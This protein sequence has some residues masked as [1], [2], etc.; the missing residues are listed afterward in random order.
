MRF[1]IKFFFFFFLLGALFFF[2]P[3]LEETWIFVQIKFLEV[4]P[5]SFKNRGSGPLR[6]AEKMLRSEIL[7]DEKKGLELCVALANPT[8]L[9]EILP[10]LRVEN[11][12]LTEL[13]L[14]AIAAMASLEMKDPL[15]KIVKTADAK[16]R[17]AI[18]LVL[19]ETLGDTVDRSQLFY[20][21]KQDPS[22]VIRMALCDALALHPGKDT[23]TILKELLSDEELE[24]AQSAST[25]L[26]NVG[27]ENEYSDIFTHFGSPKNWIDQWRSLRLITLFPEK[28]VT[29]LVARYVTSSYPFLAV[30]AL[31]W[32]MEKGD[33]R[34]FS[35]IIQETDKTP[36]GVLKAHAL[37][38]IAVLAPMA[39]KE[40][41][42]LLT[43]L[44]FLKMDNEDLSAAALE[45][46]RVLKGTLAEQE[47]LTFLDNPN[48]ELAAQA[49]LTLGSFANERY[50]DTLLGFLQ[51]EHAPL[52]IAAYRALLE[53]SNIPKIPI[54]IHPCTS[55]E[56]AEM[57]GLFLLSHTADET[58]KSLLFSEYQNAASKNIR[59]KLLE[60][61]ALVEDT[62]SSLD[63]VKQL[64]KSDLN[65]FEKAKAILDR[66]SLKLGVPAMIGG[67]LYYR[68]R[69]PKN[70]AYSLFSYSSVSESWWDHKDTLYLR[71]KEGEGGKLQGVIVHEDYRAY[72]FA[73]SPDEVIQI[74]KRLLDGLHAS[75]L[76]ALRQLQ[77]E[78]PP[79]TQYFRR[80]LERKQW[81][82]SGF[83]LQ[84]IWM[85]IEILQTEIAH[86]PVAKKTILEMKS[87]WGIQSTHFENT[88]REFGMIKILQR[89]V[90]FRKIEA[91]EMEK[92]T[93]EVLELKKKQAH[94]KYQ[95]G[96]EFSAKNDPKKAIQSF[97][98][99]L[100]LWAFHADS[101]KHI[102]I[103]YAQ[104]GHYD[105]ALQ[106]YAERQ[107]EFPNDVNGLNSISLVCRLKGD[108]EKAL[109]V[110]IQEIEVDP[111][112]ERGYLDVADLFTTHLKK[113]N[114]AEDLLEKSLSIVKNA[115]PIHFQLAKIYAKRKAVD[116]AL[117][118]IQ[119][120]LK[121][122]PE[123]PETW[124][125]LGY[126]YFLSGKEQ[127]AIAALNKAIIFD[128]SNINARLTLADVYISLGRK[129][130]AEAELRKILAIAPA[131]QEA[132]DLLEALKK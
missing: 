129:K 55:V 33:A 72:Y 112:Q 57:L 80:A 31:D 103:A 9:P 104:L 21:F 32:M 22:W 94:A 71:G 96:L 114:E 102:G 3:T 77:R 35:L 30:A 74:E 95:E 63:L 126:L 56:E 19:S 7:E 90:S 116:L 12:R 105:E 16:T 15:M 125:Y 131:N 89:F 61:R 118:H 87:F 124:T 86:H 122:K 68:E 26:A 113:D 123:D 64:S 6:V 117:P 59:L 50:R 85:Q 39:K 98:E 37:K 1:G 81:D 23:I 25:A 83:L 69:Q 115:T 121:E 84:K 42:V 127:D 44:K 93:P 73:H 128:L 70:T 11:S 65:H 24:V 62:V 27:F 132:S 108:F 101:L 91:T 52:R 14:N 10:F 43:L 58:A 92:L 34:D 46:I 53:Y 2:Y 106:F 54:K 66:S 28:L 49:I 47:V 45:G 13:A 88:L 5:A 75:P 48:L 110:L 111:T 119:N 107:Q 51:S 41:Q 67:F 97:K 120:C 109:K 60:Y 29:L 18:L 17:L 36:S 82:F 20:P 130:D 40:D 76:L 100:D 8:L 38:A 4:D 99:A 78:L 79:W